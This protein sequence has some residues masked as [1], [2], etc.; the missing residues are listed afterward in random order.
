MMRPQRTSD[1][2]VCGSIHR[3]AP[4]DAQAGNWDIF[5]PAFQG[6]KRGFEPSKKVL[7]TALMQSETWHG[8]QN[9]P[10]FEL[11]PTPHSPILSSSAEA[12]STVYSQV[13]SEL[14]PTGVGRGSPDGTRETVAWLC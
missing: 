6:Q 3:V 8:L 1:F 10:V 12:A 2:R 7:G 4:E 5:H 13:W 9:R 11:R 14:H